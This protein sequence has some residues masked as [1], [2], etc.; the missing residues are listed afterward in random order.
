MKKININI[1]FVIL[2]IIVVAILATF[3]ILLQKNNQKLVDDTIVE[4]SNVEFT[5]NDIKD[6]FLDTTFASSKS[7][8]TA[9]L[10]AFN[11]F[12]RLIVMIE[13]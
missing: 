1:I 6:R 11:A 9:V 2:I 5:L 7:F 12:S 3:I 13:T 10:K 4:I 8:K